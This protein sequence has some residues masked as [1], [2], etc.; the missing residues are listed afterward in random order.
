MIALEERLKINDNQMQNRICKG[1]LVWRKHKIH[2]TFGDNFG[3]LGMDCILDN[4]IVLV[5]HF[6]NVFYSFVVI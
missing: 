3:N 6:L 1:I 5:L 4:I 2:R